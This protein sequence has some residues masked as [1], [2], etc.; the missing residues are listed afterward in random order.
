MRDE[1]APIS[2][3]F[4]N[5]YGGWGA[6]LFDSL[7]TLLIM[8]M[9]KEYEEAVEA[10]LSLDITSWTLEAGSLSVF[11]TN[12]RHL[13]GLLAAYDLRHCKDGRLLDKAVQ[14]GDMLYLAFDTPNRILVNGWYPAVAIAGED[15]ILGDSSMAQLGSLSLEFTHLSQLTGDMRWY[16]AIQR[17]TTIFD[18]QQSRT[19]IPGLWPTHYRL[20][21]YSRV[22]FSTE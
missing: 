19:M 15:Q 12:I 9:R 14:I 11:E 20:D 17:I 18:E 2:R 10:A 3:G 5:H 4:F 16:D 8:G 22:D 6:T 7:D 1:L 13:G 21:N